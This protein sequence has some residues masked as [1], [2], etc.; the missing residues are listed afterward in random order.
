[1]RQANVQKPKLPETDRRFGFFFAAH[2]SNG[3]CLGIQPSFCD[4]HGY[5]RGGQETARPV[6]KVS[7][8]GRM[9]AGK[10]TF[11][12]RIERTL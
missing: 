8:K 3:G 5:E 2:D 10:N 7:R 11:I 1:M 6:S 9:G 12:C 4:F